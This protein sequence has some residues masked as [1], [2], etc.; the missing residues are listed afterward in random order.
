[1]AES[2][3]DQVTLAERARKYQLVFKR[4]QENYGTP[5]WRQ[6]L[7]PVDELVSTI[8]SQSTSD[9]NRDKGFYALKAHYAD[10]ESVM[11][12][13]EQEI[14]ETIRPAGL[15]NQKG[16]RI[17]AALQYI[18]EQR[19]VIELNFL[20]DMS[21]EEAKAWLAR[22]KGVGPK[23]AAIVLLFAF[24]RPAFPVDTH[25]HRLARRIGLINPGTSANKAHEMIEDIAAPETY[26][27]MHLNL[28]RH[29]REI[30]KA[31]NPKCRQCI[32]QELCD[33]FPIE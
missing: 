9:I 22:I 25:V 23:T 31:R 12:A 32:L 6:H 30:C 8:L 26:Y 4:L 10:W 2:E 24:D 28:I 5:Q 14:I 29:G 27:P 20:N 18:R 17:Q 13:P 1:M 15:A 21:I 3:P 11:N 33:S 7:E 16:P 19:G